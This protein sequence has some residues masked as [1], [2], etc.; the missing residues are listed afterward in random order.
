VA[1]LADAPKSAVEK[2][3]EERVIRVKK[4]RRGGRMRRMLPA[5]AVA[6]AKILRSLKYRMDPT[7]KRRLASALGRVEA[8]GWRASRFELE[9]AVEVDVGRLVGETM[10]R[11]EAYGAARDEVIVENEAILGGT[12]VIRGTRLSVHAIRGRR[13]AGDTMEAIL[14]DY[15]HLTPEMIETA[16]IYA[17]AHPLVGRPGGRPWA[18]A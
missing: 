14:E 8:G 6:Y 12:P 10:A 17:R 4:V 7:L 18:A 13:E 5:H 9:P 3:I 2:A 15:P 11:A 1:E 16:T